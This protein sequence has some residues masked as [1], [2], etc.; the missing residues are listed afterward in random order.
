MGNP[1]LGYAVVTKT[2]DDPRN[3]S[4]ARSKALTTVFF[5]DD[6]C[7]RLALF[8]F[9]INNLYRF[10]FIAQ[11]FDLSQS[12]QVVFRESI[13]NTPGFATGALYEV[14]S[15]AT[16]RFTHYV[17]GNI[18]IFDCLGSTEVVG[19]AIQSARTVKSA[20]GAI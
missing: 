14:G 20:N 3:V 8:A 13:E 16:V 12:L 9:L 17:E 2:V 10:F 1:I 4:G 15:G 19:A 18:E 7:R 6:E 5:A 11:T